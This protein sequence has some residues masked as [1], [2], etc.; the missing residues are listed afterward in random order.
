M[1]HAVV[2]GA[3]VLAGGKKITDLASNCVQCPGGKAAAHWRVSKCYFPSFLRA[4]RVPLQRPLPAR[5]QAPCCR[6]QNSRGV[7]YGAN[8]NL[9][10]NCFLGRTVQIQLCSLLLLDYWSRLL[11][12]CQH[13]LTPHLRGGYKASPL[14]NPT[15]LFHA[16]FGWPSLGGEEWDRASVFPRSAHSSSL[17]HAAGLAALMG[18]SILVFVSSSFSYFVSCRTR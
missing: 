10:C 11:F 13:L 16:R 6:E 8:L 3:H 9:L 7:V 17:F 12:Y 18:W 14:L 4:G 5:W 15:C 1:S 2:P